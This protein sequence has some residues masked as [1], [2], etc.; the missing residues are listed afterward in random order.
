MTADPAPAGIRAILLDIEGT[1]T[2]LSFVFDVLFPYARRHLHRYLAQQGASPEMAARL[3]S[4]MDR[5]SKDPEL[6]TVQ[7]KI[8][9]E[10]YRNGELI[11]EVFDDVPA[12]FERWHALGIRIGIFSSGSVLAQQLLF[13]HS[14]AGDLT[15]CLTWHFDTTTGTKADADS[16]RRIAAAM[17]I[18]TDVVVF[19]SDTT[20]ELDAARAAGMQTRLAIRP[21]NAPPSDGHGFPVLRR[22]DEV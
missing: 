1:T 22:F 5:D 15:R 16:Y 19:I 12:A 10:G 3:E 8:W 7:G 9:E 2:P 11:G 17:A 20:R 6:K 18:P 21:G 14:T 4:L 13:R